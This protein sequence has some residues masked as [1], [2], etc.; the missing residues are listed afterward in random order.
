MRWVDR[1]LGL[2]QPGSRV[3][4]LGCGRGIPYTKRL[5]EQHE[6]TGVDL[7]ARQI[8]LAQEALPEATFLCA[9]VAKLELPAMSF[10]AAVSLFMLGHIP[11]DEQPEVLRRIAGWLRPSG[12]VLLTMGT[13][14]TVGI[15]PDWLGA[16]MYF[17]SWPPDENSALLRAAGFE[18][19][20]DRVITHQ[21]SGHGDVSFM[22]VL[23]RKR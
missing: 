4:D 7:S 19:L 23:A 17:S 21:E 5:S 16:P 10:D 9:D 6:V 13:S 20:D 14:G 3:L 12:L 1:L 11:R 8:E 2:L 15:D 18:L 22:W